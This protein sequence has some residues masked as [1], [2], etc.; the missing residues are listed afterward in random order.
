MAKNKERAKLYNTQHKAHY[1]VWFWRTIPNWSDPGHLAQGIDTDRSAKFC[2]KFHLLP[3]EGP[4]VLVTTNYPDLRA[5]VGHFVVLRLNGLEA[6]D[7]ITLLTKLAD[8]LEVE[9]LDQKSLDSKAYWL[10]WERSAKKVFNVLG[11]A[12]KKV[13]LS[14]HAGPVQAEVEGG[15]EKKKTSPHATE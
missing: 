11:D 13:K 14:I 4:H 9:G 12:V 10:S 6:D 5:P 15:S 7:F 2:E 1:A 8:Q 3:S